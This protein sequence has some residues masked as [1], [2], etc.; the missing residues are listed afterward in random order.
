MMELIISVIAK[1]YL[2]AGTPASSIAFKL[3]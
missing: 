3:L 2:I 1:P